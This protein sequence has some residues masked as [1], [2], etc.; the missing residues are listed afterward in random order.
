MSLTLIQ[1]YENASAKKW[2]V[3]RG[4][5]LCKVEPVIGVI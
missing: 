2:F 5:W 3:V 1:N 4:Y